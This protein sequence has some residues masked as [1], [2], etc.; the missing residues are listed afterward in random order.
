MPLSK[1]TFQV[2]LVLLFNHVV[3]PLLDPAVPSLSCDQCEISFSYKYNQVKHQKEIHENSKVYECQR[4]QG[5]FQLYRDFRTHI[6]GCTKDFTCGVCGNE[7]SFRNSLIK[8]FFILSEIYLTRLTLIEANLRKKYI[9][10]R[11]L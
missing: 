6:N 11:R 5:H 9:F 7:F 10:R 1:E 8:H 4:C 2:L 3:L